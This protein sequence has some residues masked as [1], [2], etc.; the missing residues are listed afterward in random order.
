MRVL[1]TLLVLLLAGCAAPTLPEPLTHTSEC[2]AALPDP[3]P[4]ERG[5][6]TVT[7]LTYT[8]FGFAPE[9]FAEFT[10][11][12]G[13]EV[14]LVTAGDAGEV[15]SKA[16]LTSGAPVA[17]ALFGVDNVL[18]AR[19]RDVFDPYVSPELA[20]VDA[21]FR[22]PFCADGTM[23]ATPVDHGYVA[24]NVDTAWLADPNSPVPR[25]LSDVATARVA[26]YVVVE[27]PYT[28]SP[29]TAFFL[30]TVATL[31][32]D[33]AMRWWRDLAANGGRIATDWDTAYG[34]D[35]TQGYD[36]TGRRDRPIVV[37]Y[38]TSPAYN[39]MN[40][41]GNATSAVLDIPGA[42]WHQVEAIGV[43]K[44][45]KEPDGAK[46]L[47]DWMLAKDVQERFAAKQVTYPVRAD[48]AAPEAYAEHAPEPRE[49]ASLPA[50]TVEA[51]RE[52]WLKAWRDAVGQ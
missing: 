42:A 39:P 51:N 28:S 19:A 35:F 5:S 14:A 22:A 45:A 46:A 25:N 17:D 7:L 9:D 23:L 21:R 27:N 2:P 30:A 48:A 16:V 24:L 49:P 36:D 12:T 18:I 40:G 47:V 50:E 43:L 32:E 34:K 41:Y 38:A 10:E 4:V 44:G 26:P 15:V 1:A 3:R 11:E 6:G 31:G 52:R 33:A 20:H 29:G 8:S 13:Y 37:S